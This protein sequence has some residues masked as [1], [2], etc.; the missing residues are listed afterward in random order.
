MLLRMLV[1]ET[2]TVVA[3]AA[4]FEMEQTFA[5]AAFS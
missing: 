2:A 5:S 3:H 4:S 1:I